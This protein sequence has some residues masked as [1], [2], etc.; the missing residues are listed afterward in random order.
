[1]LHSSAARVVHQVNQKTRKN[2]KAE[3]YLEYAEDDANPGMNPSAC[4]RIRTSFFQGHDAQDERHEPENGA[5]H[6]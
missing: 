3:E 1:M 4:R 6:A 5:E 2:Q